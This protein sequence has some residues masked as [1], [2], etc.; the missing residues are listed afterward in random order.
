MK[1][2]LRIKFSGLE[3]LA[4]LQKIAEKDQE[5]KLKKILLRREELE[6]RERELENCKQQKNQMF[7]YLQTHNSQSFQLLLCK[8]QNKHQPR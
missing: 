7:E 2:N 8:I 3:T 4:Y 6:L 1:L 5:F